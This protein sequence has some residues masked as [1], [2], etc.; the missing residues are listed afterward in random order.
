MPWSD[1]SSLH[2]IQL[3]RQTVEKSNYRD[4]RAARGG[5]VA[6][7]ARVKSTLPWGSAL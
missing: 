7:V 1:G 4:G 5:M 3:G 2:G 6:A